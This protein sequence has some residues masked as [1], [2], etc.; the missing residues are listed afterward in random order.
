MANINIGDEIVKAIQEG[1]ILQCKATCKSTGKRCNR[2]ARTGYEVCSSHGAGTRKRV[3]LAQKKNPG[4]PISPYEAALTEDEQ[5]VFEQNIGDLT[6]VNEVALIKTKLTSFIIDL[7]RIQEILEET[8]DE[9]GWSTVP[10]DPEERAIFWANQYERV[11][12]RL[13]AI[14]R[15]VKI[16]DDLLLLTKTLEAVTKTTVAAW[17]QLQGK[18]IVVTM[19]QVNDIAMMDDVRNLVRQELDFIKEMLCPACQQRVLSAMTERQQTII[20]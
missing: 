9:G 4:R 14:E 11:S 1:K 8:E 12:N 5:A 6:L 7:S 16:Q 2:P 20:G 17:E 15:K 3:A 18:K 13:S 10:E 19:E